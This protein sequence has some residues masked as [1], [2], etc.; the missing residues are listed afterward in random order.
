MDRKIQISVRIDIFSLK[1]IPFLYSLRSKARPPSNSP[2][3]EEMAKTCH[4]DS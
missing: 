3:G 4:Q 1:N 2:E